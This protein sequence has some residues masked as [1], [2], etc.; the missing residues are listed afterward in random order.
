[1]LIMG[2][3]LFGQDRKNLQIAK[4]ILSKKIYKNIYEAQKF[5]DIAN[6]L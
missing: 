4:E 2:V 3:Y 6:S 1:M 5:L